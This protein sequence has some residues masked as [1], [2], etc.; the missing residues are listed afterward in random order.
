MSPENG[1]QHSKDDLKRRHLLLLLPCVLGSAALAGA[2]GAAQPEAPAATAQGKHTA[3]LPGTYR[4]INLGPGGLSSLPRINDKDQVAFTHDN[5]RAMF[6]DGTSVQD[7]GTLGG[8]QAYA[9]DLNNAGQVVGSSALPGD[10]PFSHAYLW[11]R[12][13]GM[14]DLGTLSGNR[15]GAVAINNRGQVAGS[16]G[17]SNS[18]PHA[19][20]W[21]PPFG[22]EDIG[23][24]PGGDFTSATD[25]S[26][27]GLVTGW[28]STANGD[29]HAFAWTRKTG[30]V[31]LGT[32][33]G[34]FSYAEA[35]NARGQVAGY[36]TVPG[37]RAWHA[38][39]WDAH[40][41]LRDLGTAGGTESFSLALNDLGQ[42]PGRPARVLMDACPRHRRPRHAGRSGRARPR[43]QQQGAG[44]G[45]LP[46]QGRDVPRLPLERQTG[47][48]RPEQA[49]APRAGRAGRGL[50]QRDLR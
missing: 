23:L 36:A 50:R 41:G 46:H 5:I 14:I 16:S 35:T 11:S 30:L 18:F 7:I 49:P 32:L 33:G 15:S 25:I 43:R 40:H 20:R 2:V 1:P 44:R 3:A 8:S 10:P 19:F 38:F 13:T 6:Y 37:N 27:T 24:F 45:R 22:L 39:V 42:C 29:G 21:S 4:V 34:S 26:D 31:D 12:A 9:F 48:G 47:H 28:G 17:S